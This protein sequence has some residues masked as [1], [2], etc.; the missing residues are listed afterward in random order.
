MTEVYEYTSAPWRRAILDISRGTKTKAI[1]GEKGSPPLDKSGSGYMKITALFRMLSERRDIRFDKKEK[2]FN[3]MDSRF[4]E[5]KK[6][7]KEMDSRFVSF[8]KDIKNT[9]QR[10]EELQLRV[11]RPRQADMG[12]KEGKSGELDGIATEAGERTVTPTEPQRQQPLLPSQPPRL[13]PQQPM[14]PQSSMFQPPPPPSQPPP[15]QHY[16][17]PLHQSRPLPSTPFSAGRQQLY[18]APSMIGT[19]S[20]RSPVGAGARS[21]VPVGES[22]AGIPWKLIPQVFTGD[23]VHFRSLEKEVIMFADYVG[24]GYVL[25]DTREILVSD[26]SISYAELRSLG[27]IDDEID[28]HRR[29]Y[30]FLLSAITPEIEASSTT[31]IHRQKPRETKKRGTTQIPYLPHKLSTNAFSNTP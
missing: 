11:P 21:A 8:Q 12:I 4:D 1:S 26:P 18:S 6:R 31:P 25:K 7:F 30:Q 19:P 15:L 28:T 20:H 5:Q 10:L 3:E 29:A 2:R 13:P 22:L 24:F 9:N 27:F 16:Q 17:S 14:M 23:S